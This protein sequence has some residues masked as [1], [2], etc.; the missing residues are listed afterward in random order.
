MKFKLE[1]C[2]NKKENEKPNHIS[3][4][5]RRIEIFCKSDW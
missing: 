5:F 3:E 2:L 1:F 4:K